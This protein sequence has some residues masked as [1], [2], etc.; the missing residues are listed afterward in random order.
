MYGMCYFFLLP[1]VANHPSSVPSIR[2]LETAALRQRRALRKGKVILVAKRY[3]KS[4]ER[5]VSTREYTI[6]FDGQRNRTEQHYLFEASQPSGFRRTYCRGCDEGE[7]IFY[8]DEKDK[9]GATVG[10]EVR[11]GQ[12]TKRLSRLQ[13][14]NPR[15][16]GMYPDTVSNLA[17][18]NL[19]SVLL[20]PDQENMKI[21]Q[22]EWRGH[23]CYRIHF[24]S[25]TKANWRVWVVPDWGHSVVRI[26][27]EADYYGKHYSSWVE[28]DVQQYKKSGLWYPR[29]CVYERH[30]NGSFALRQI[31]EV[32]HVELNED[33]PPDTFSLRGMNLPIG[34][35]IVGLS[36]KGSLIWDGEKPVRRKKQPNFDTT[37]LKRTR[38]KRYGL[39]V[40]S[41]LF[42]AIAAIYVWRFLSWR[43]RTN[44]S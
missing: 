16:L 21:V 4:P 20:R 12:K 15:M 26:S 6:W 32:R 41:I 29:S 39:I 2:D 19:E 23:R 37:R 38:S 33:L 43:T 9:V 36:E 17:H 31:T 14:V 18:K 5:L 42:A 22:I 34:K 35:S 30:V 3:I 8:S 7:Y 1:L 25:H 10:V 13:Q 44:Q 28:S 11:T 24:N 40:A 27:A